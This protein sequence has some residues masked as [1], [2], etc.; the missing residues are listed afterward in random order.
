M[1]VDKVES[2]EVAGRGPAAC[3]YS[4]WSA[5]WPAAQALQA[6]L[7]FGHYLLLVDL[8][9]PPPNQISL[10]RWKTRKPDPLT[11]PLLV[12]APSESGSGTTTLLAHHQPTT[13]KRK[14][15][16]DLHE[17]LALAESSC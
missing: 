10:K 16:G 3:Q 9:P 8:F 15:P 14:H 5:R 11:I 17:A 4:R 13:G 12:P 2:Q 6:F 7:E 1:L